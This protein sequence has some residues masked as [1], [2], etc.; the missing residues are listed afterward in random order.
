MNK[1]LTREKISVIIPTY[2][3]S[4]TIAETIR[5]LYY[6]MN[7]NFK[8]FVINDR[9][10]DS[11]LNI[12]KNLK[13]KYRFSIINN[14]INLGKVKSLNKAFKRTKGKIIFVLDSDVIVNKKM[15]NNSISRL[16]KHNIGAVSCRYRV[17]NEGFISQMIGVEFAMLALSQS[18]KAISLW[19]GC[20]FIKRDLLERAGLFQENMLTEDMD[21]ALSLKEMGWK[22]DQILEPA[23]TYESNNLKAWF[24]QKIRWAS[25]GMQCFLKHPKQFIKNPFYFIYLFSYSIISSLFFFSLFTHLPENI[26]LL[27]SLLYILLTSFFSA[28]NINNLNELG[29]I[30]LAIPYAFIYYPVFSMI[31]TMGFALGV[32]KYFKLKNGARAW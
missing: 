3:D 13:N 8:L 17:K 2:N 24:K 28:M 11:T 29:N 5:N 15:I 7:I 25:G 14:K 9:S 20:M 1:K 27:V 32:Y 19:G 22:L 6:S 10:T 21:M 23:E 4:N 26:V 16:K 31:V 12:L 30:L 18:I